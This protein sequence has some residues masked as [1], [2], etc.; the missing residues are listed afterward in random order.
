[1]KIKIDHHNWGEMM[2]LYHALE[3]FFH[4]G[5]PC[6]LG[7]EGCD[8]VEKEFEEKMRTTG[9][10]STSTQITP[11]QVKVLTEMQDTVD[12]GWFDGC[13]CC[14]DNSLHNMDEA[15]AFE[16]LVKELKQ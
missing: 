11:E 5:S 16:E 6:A 13:G 8:R 2:T 15:K 10:L 12:D 4:Q 7:E 9:M 1:M 14:A 3:H